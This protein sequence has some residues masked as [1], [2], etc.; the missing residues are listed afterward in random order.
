M[1]T[2][3]VA[4]VDSFQVGLPPAYRP[5][6]VKG[7]S[8]TGWK[9]SDAVLAGVRCCLSLAVVVFVF[10]GGFYIGYLQNELAQRTK[11]E[12]AKTFAVRFHEKGNIVQEKIAVNL[13]TQTETFFGVKHN[14]VPKFT[15][16]NDF[17][18]GITVV[19][20]PSAG[21]CY[22]RVLDTTFPKPQDLKNE[23]DAHANETWDE[24]PREYHYFKTVK[25]A[26]GDASFLPAEIKSH[27]QGLPVYWTVPVSSPGVNSRQRR[28]A[29][30][31]R[32]SVSLSL[33]LFGRNIIT[34][35]ISV[36]TS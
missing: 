24:V 25:P 6:E 16:V 17:K 18:Q 33:R 13:Q 10:T 1:S 5:T 20:V 19:H 3:K 11:L 2:E 27:C 30:R 21:A 12:Q 4:T 8:K 9:V 26:I 7:Q 36:E 28:R 15:A 23:L 34:V 31:R 14:D 22:V 32:R 29:A 35:T